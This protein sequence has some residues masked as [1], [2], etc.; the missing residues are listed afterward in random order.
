MAAGN[1]QYRLH[2]QASEIKNGQGERDTDSTWKTLT[3]PAATYTHTCTC[4]HIPLTPANIQPLKSQMAFLYLEHAFVTWDVPGMAKL[5]S[6]CAQEGD[7]VRSKAERGV[8]RCSLCWE[9]GIPIGCASRP[10][11]SHLASSLSPSQLFGRAWIISLGM[12][13]FAVSLRFSGIPDL[14]S[15]FSGKPQMVTKKSMAAEP[16]SSFPQSVI[17]M[18]PLL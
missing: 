6:R 15:P 1:P 18:P 8:S 11:F 12:M 9:T 2:G 16:V 10:S 13:V 5:P 4:E 7:V 17:Q 3:S 14:T